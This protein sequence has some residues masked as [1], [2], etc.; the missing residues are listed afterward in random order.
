[1][2]IKRSPDV[3]GLNISFFL[4]LFFHVT[5]RNSFALIF[6]ISYL[7]NVGLTL[8]SRLKCQVRR[9]A[10]ETSEEESIENEY[11]VS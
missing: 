6:H 8:R 10:N 3:E 4:P 2:S 1:M 9:Q 5:N 11:L 7:A